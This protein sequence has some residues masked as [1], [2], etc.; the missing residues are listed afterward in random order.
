[1]TLE[2]VYKGI[3]LC[4]KKIDSAAKFIDY[5]IHDILDFSILKNGDKSFVPE[6][7][8]ANIRETV[9]QITEMQEDKINL[10]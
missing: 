4:G 5:F 8:L 2:N 1:L 10:K 3:G 6:L 7:N 9:T